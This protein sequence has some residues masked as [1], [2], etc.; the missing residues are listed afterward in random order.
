MCQKAGLFMKKSTRLVYSGGSR[1]RIRP[2]RLPAKLLRIRE[3]LNLTQGELIEKLD[4]PDSITQ[5]H[6]S[7][8]EKGKREPD[9]LSLLAYARAAG[10][11]VEVLIDDRLD[12]PMQLPSKRTYHSHK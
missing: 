5:P 4:M 2:M 6:I 1:P 3:A 10:I 7:S 9:L 8:W 11:C 12:L